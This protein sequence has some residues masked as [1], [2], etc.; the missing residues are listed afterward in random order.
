MT[1]C[2]IEYQHGQFTKISWHL[3]VKQVMIKILKWI[4]REETELAVT[5]SKEYLKIEIFYV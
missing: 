4:N 1:V 2:V 5:Q 3:S